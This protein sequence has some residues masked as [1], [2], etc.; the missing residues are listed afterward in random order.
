MGGVG[1]VWVVWATGTGTGTGTSHRAFSCASAVSQSALGVRGGCFTAF[2]SR[3]FARGDAAVAVRA[4]ALMDSRAM[5]A[6]PDLQGLD[7]LEAACLALPHG[8]IS[9]LVVL[10]ETALVELA[11]TGITEALHVEQHR[12]EESRPSIIINPRAPRTERGKSGRCWCCLGYAPTTQVQRTAQMVARLQAV[13]WPLSEID[14]T[15]TDRGF[16]GLRTHLCDLCIATEITPEHAQTISAAV[17]TF[18]AR[19][20]RAKEDVHPH[21]S[22]DERRAK[23]IGQ[24]S[25]V[26]IDSHDL[27]PSIP[28]ADVGMP[29]PTP[30]NMPPNML[31]VRDD[32]MIS[33]MLQKHPHLIDPACMPTEM[34]PS[35]SSLPDLTACWY[36]GLQFALSHYPGKSAVSGDL[37]FLSD[38][39]PSLLEGLSFLRVT[40]R[41][42]LKADG[43][44]DE[45]FST[46]GKRLL[47]RRHR[48]Q[49]APQMLSTLEGL[50]ALVLRA[51]WRAHSRC[52]GDDQKITACITWPLEVQPERFIHLCGSLRAECAAHI[53]QGTIKAAHCGNMFAEGALRTRSAAGLQTSARCLYSHH[54]LV[55]RAA[56]GEHGDEVF[57]PSPHA[58]LSACDALDVCYAALNIELGQAMQNED[59]VFE[60]DL[61]LASFSK[62]P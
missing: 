5:S 54:A 31:Q 62:P 9:D 18:Y 48:A 56:S 55:S 15:S 23:T 22:V 3:N 47:E 17:T 46:L 2:K 59:L 43:W 28:P 58:L 13:G 38:L 26:M 35:P 44:A 33:N 39:R 30:P 49:A 41:Q 7:T 11:E 14:R 27:I 36:A 51:L 60:H 20:S 24:S 16:N 52:G 8:S 34:Q 50:V 37:K 19:A 53:S 61:G 25:S 4:R 6:L 10:A 1:P 32:F 29:M 42:T 12:N 40:D 45:H 21:R 57:P